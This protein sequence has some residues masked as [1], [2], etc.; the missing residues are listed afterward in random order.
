MKGRGCNNS[1][2]RN[3]CTPLS[4]CWE[5]PFLLSNFFPFPLRSS[6]SSPHPRGDR[7]RDEGV[8]AETPGLFLVEKKKI[9]D[10]KIRGTSRQK[11][12]REIVLEVVLWISGLLNQVSLH[13]S[14]WVLA[15]FCARFI[16]LDWFVHHCVSLC[17][18]Y[19]ACI[20]NVRVICHLVALLLS[21]IHWSG[22]K[23]SESTEIYMQLSRKHTEMFYLDPLHGYI[24]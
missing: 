10:E 22:V 12:K 20:S 13:K 14:V 2:P 3:V 24:F 4:L 18:L 5:F 19:F 9:G 16:V 21:T 23:A 11:R 6:H 15:Y 7:L 8:P 1:H 17:V